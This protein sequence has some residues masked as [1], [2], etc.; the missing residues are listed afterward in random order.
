MFVMENFNF[1]LVMKT[2]SRRR[3]KILYFGKKFDGTS[4]SEV[5]FSC[6]LLEILTSAI[7]L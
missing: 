6:D 7:Q 2:V 1:Q 5:H 4:K 3:L